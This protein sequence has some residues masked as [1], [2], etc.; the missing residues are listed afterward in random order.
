[1]P[2]MLGTGGS[3]Q[4]GINFTQSIRHVR[5]TV[6]LQAVRARHRR[7]CQELE[8]DH[9]RQLLS[10][11]RGLL[12]VQLNES[13]VMSLLLVLP[14]VIVDRAMDKLHV[15]LPAIPLSGNNRRQVVHV[16]CAS[17]TKQYKLIPVKGQWCPV[18]GKVTIGLVLHWPCI[19]DLSGL[20]TYRLSGLVR[21]M[22]TTLLGAWS[23]L[24]FYG[25]PASQMRTLYFC[26]VSF[27]LLFFLA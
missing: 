3:L 16:H 20:S 14:S 18:A 23:A 15:W 4:S 6:Q 22:S 26:P 25:C 11:A 19:V 9:R 5:P 27:F 8:Q 7:H 12:K 24:S 21:E 10:S 1:M 17:V 13:T 2:L